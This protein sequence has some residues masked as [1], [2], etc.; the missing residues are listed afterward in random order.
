MVKGQTKNTIRLQIR[1]YDTMVKGQTK[2]T[3]GQTTIC[4]TLHN[5]QS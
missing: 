5:I 1:E 4:K 3:N 2:K